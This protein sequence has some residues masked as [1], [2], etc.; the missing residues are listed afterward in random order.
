MA[1]TPHPQIHYEAGEHP[2]VAIKRHPASD[3]TDEFWTVS[4]SGERRPQMDLFFQDF[5]DIE[6]FQTALNDAVQRRHAAAVPA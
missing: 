4:L 3:S 6:A 1:Y 5:A 2:N